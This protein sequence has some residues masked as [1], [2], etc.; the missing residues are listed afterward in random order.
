M[1]LDEPA[2]LS[3]YILTRQSEGLQAI[4]SLGMTSIRVI[5]KQGKIVAN[6]LRTKVTV[7]HKPYCVYLQKKFL[8][9]GC[10]IQSSACSSGNFSKQSK[11][12]SKQ[13]YNTCKKI[14]SF[15]SKVVRREPRESSDF[16]NS[17]PRKKQTH[18]QKRSQRFTAVVC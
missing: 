1:D 5:W 6:L 17:E 10:E 11:K 9:Q 8:K 12:N 15:Q 13:G 14:K 7:R 2:K 4:L 18:C 3:I 16:Q